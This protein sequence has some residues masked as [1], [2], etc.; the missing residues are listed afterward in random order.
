[1]ATT[2]GTTRKRKNRETEAQIEDRAAPIATLEIDSDGEKTSDQDDGEMDDFPELDT[3]SDKTSSDSDE[4]SDSEASESSLKNS[5]K[6][7]ELVVS[8]ITGRLKRVYPEI[9]PEYDSDSSTED[10][11]IFSNDC[12]IY[13]E[14]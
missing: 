12:G 13:I 2:N 8:S 3:G 7:G 1:M 6:P 11:C 4:E 14:A 9:E 5:A 10:V